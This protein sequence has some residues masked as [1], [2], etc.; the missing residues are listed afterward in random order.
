MTLFDILDK[1]KN[2]K[3]PAIALAPMAGF[4]DAAFRLLCT[5]MGCDMSV[6][7]MIS[8]KAMVYRDKKT[9]TLAKIVEGEA[10]VAIQLF[11]HEPEVMCE[12]ADMVARGDFEGC[13]FAKAP[14]AIDIN[15]G[16]PVKKI[17]S[18]GDGSALMKDPELC[19][20]IV[21]QT[22]KGAGELPV[23][24][25]IRAGITA[26]TK[27]AVEV[28]LACAEGGAAA[29]CV[30]G[31][32][33]EQMYSPGVDL[34]IIASVRD[35]LD[36]DIYVIANGDI[37]SRDDAVRVAEYTGADAVM[38]GR[39][40]LGDPWLFG[41]V[42]PTEQERL[43]TAYELIEAIVAECGE[44]TGVRE[45][46]GRAAHFIRGLRGAAEMR[47]ALNSAETLEEIRA[48]LMPFGQ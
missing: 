47:C 8:A 42:V 18:S 23:T 35:A 39:A 41:G 12:A 21:A 11:G 1:K 20:D 40:A 32:T 37:A 34:D 33:R 19:R 22:K 24:V 14:I 16:C 48:I 17:F 29:V 15:M 38:V 13:S 4:T 6:S 26:S 5:R 43:Q 36:K 27:N 45:S 31:R 9:A 46:R 25:K 3:I 2:T 44:Y 7:E 10:P 30:H 28:A